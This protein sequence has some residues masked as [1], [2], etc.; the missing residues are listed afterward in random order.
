MAGLGQRPSFD[1]NVK[2]KTSFLLEDLQTEVKESEGHLGG[3][4]KIKRTIESN[5]KMVR[6]L[7]FKNNRETR[8]LNCLFLLY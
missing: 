8:N 3:N 5:E 2:R 6:W 7:K 1:K 4:T